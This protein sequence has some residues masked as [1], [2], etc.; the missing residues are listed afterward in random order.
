MLEDQFISMA[1]SIQIQI[2]DLCS[3][4]SLNKHKYYV[5]ERKHFE[6]IQFVL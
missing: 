1:N 3:N 4:M 6:S 5:A 2:C